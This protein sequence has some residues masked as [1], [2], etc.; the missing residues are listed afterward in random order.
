MKYLL[1][2][3]HENWKATLVFSLI[4]I[5]TVVFLAAKTFGLTIATDLGDKTHEIGNMSYEKYDGTPL[6]GSEVINAIKRYQKKVPVTIYTGESV[7]TYNG[8]FEVAKNDRKSE[9]Y[10]KPSQKYYGSVLKDSD[11]EVVGLVFAKEGIALTETSYKELIAQI[12]GGDAEN[13][14]M[15][16]LISQIS[17]TI[18]AKNEAI[19]TLTDKVAQLNGS[20]S[21]LQSQ[22]STL[23][24]Q[25]N[26]LTNQLSTANTKYNNLSS[27]V[28]SGKSSIAT[29]ITNKGVTTSATA[30][31]STMATNIGKIPTGKQYKSG[32][33]SFSNSG[34]LTVTGLGFKPSMVMAFYDNGYYVFGRTGGFYSPNEGSY[35]TTTEFSWGGGSGYW[36]GFSANADGFSLR[37]I[38]SYAYSKSVTWYA[39]E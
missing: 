8:T 39:Y 38:Y 31:F 10:I 1:D 13:S 26:T 2:L 24:S 28:T 37:H 16:Q 17:G 18:T 11:E 3:V 14:T 23:Q 30:S 32:T 36:N 4:T 7:D 25:K 15:D 29:A 34:Y 33:G 9:K 12:V 35:Y 22:N 20:I 6:Q 21:T 5:S 27:E 19:Q